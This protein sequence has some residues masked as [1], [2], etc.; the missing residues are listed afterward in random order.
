MIEVCS[1]AILVCIALLFA[2][3]A[4]YMVYTAFD[5]WEL[6]LCIG[7]L[8]VALM[9]AALSAAFIYGA[10]INYPAAVTLFMSA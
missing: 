5:C 9:F 10:I 7:E 6:E 1:W 2:V 8:F 4:G 3:A